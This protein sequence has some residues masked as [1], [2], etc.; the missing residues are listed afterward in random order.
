MIAARFLGADP[1]PCLAVTRCK[2]RGAG[3]ARIYIG[4][5]DNFPPQRGCSDVRKWGR[6]SGI[7]RGYVR[8]SLVIVASR[9]TRRKDVANVVQMSPKVAVKYDNRIQAACVGHTHDMY[10]LHDMYTSPYLS[11]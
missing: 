6:S 7:R 11:L 5:L 10:N 8:G 4:A 9:G 2:L 3:S 1:H